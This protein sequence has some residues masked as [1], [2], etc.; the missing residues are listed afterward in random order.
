[1]KLLFKNHFE[2][3]VESLK[4][5]RM[6]TYLTVIGVTIGIASI[7]LILSLMGGANR[8]L[9]DQAAKVSDTIALVRPGSS[10][11]NTSLLNSSQGISPIN[12]LTEKDAD[13]ISRIGGSQAAPLSIHHTKLTPSNSQDAQKAAVIGTSG[14]LQTIADIEMREGQFVDEANGIVIGSQLAIDLFGTDHALGNIIK[15][16][17]E[18]LTVVGV[19]K[20]MKKQL[21]YLG[22]DNLDRS[23]LVPTAVSKKFTQGVPQIQQ[24]VISAANAES[25]KDTVEK[26]KNIL[27]KNH[28]GDTDYHVLI[29]REIAAPNAGLI[30]AI[31]TVVTLIAVISLVVGGVGIM[32]VMLVNVA[33]RQREVGIRKA[34]GAT[35]RNIIDQF[36]IESAIIGLFGGVLGYLVGVAAAYLISLYLPFT[37]ILHWH[38]AAWAIGVSI[39]IGIVFGIY[40]AARAAQKD[41]IESLRY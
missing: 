6:R 18:T 22:I 11:K 15:I 16:H 39:V 24:I 27:Q 38:A 8:L 28:H 3:A 14:A 29:G 2:N 31:T 33:E 26:A 40:P 36:L 21:T 19:L 23:A 5:N 41:P 35:N 30:A 4:A 13:A 9:G 34:V 12:S 37:P 1:M 32:N 10:N 7:T 17:D 20:P 25:L